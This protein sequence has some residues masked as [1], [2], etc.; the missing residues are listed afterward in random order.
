MNETD[1]GKCSI[2]LKEGDDFD[3]KDHCMYVISKKA[4]DEG[5]EFK[6]RKSDTLRHLMMNCKLKSDKQQ[7][8]F[9]KTCK[10]YTP[11]E[12]QRRI[13]NLQVLRPEAY[14]KLKDAGFETWSRETCPANRYN[15]MT[16]NSAKS[17]N[18]L[19]RHV[20]KS[21]NNDADGVVQSASTKVVLCSP[22]EISRMK[23]NANWKVYGIHQGKVYQVDDRQKVHRVDLTTRSCTCRKWQLSGIPCG[24][25]IA[26]GRVTR[27]NDCSDMA[28]VVIIIFF[29]NSYGKESTQSSWK[30]SRQSRPESNIHNNM[31]RS[32]QKYEEAYNNNHERSQEYDPA[33]TNMIGRSQEYDPAYTN[34]H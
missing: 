7:C 18:N 23:K 6:A 19:S 9:W 8:I 26:V 28:L 33:Y 21:A 14:Q 34:N 22:R 1:N 24:H 17:I 4:L 12:F 32:S 10:A 29:L 5:F 13:S 15:Y 27:C 3:N 25:V 31:I 2:I 16:S 11:E 30:R 20:R